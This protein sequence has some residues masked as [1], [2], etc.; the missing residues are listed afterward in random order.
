MNADQRGALRP[1]YPTLPAPFPGKGEDGSDMGAYEYMFTTASGV[2]VAGR[3]SDDLGRSISGANVSVMDSETGA[4]KTV[5]TNQ[6]GR[7][8][9]EGLIAG[10]VFVVSVSSK[11]SKDNPVQILNLAESLGEINFTLSR[12]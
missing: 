8:N 2:S 12:R 4:T 6:F 1:W 11:S 3:I 7:Y 5:K 10:R 9:V